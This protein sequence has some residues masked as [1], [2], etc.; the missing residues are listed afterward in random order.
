[1]KTLEGTTDWNWD[2]FQPGAN[3]GD[4]PVQNIGNVGDWSGCSLFPECPFG[5]RRDPTSSAP[6]VCTGEG[7]PIYQDLGDCLA[8]TGAT[9]TE[10]R[11]F[12]IRN[13]MEPFNTAF[14]ECLAA[15]NILG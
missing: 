4:P 6:I 9:S 1:M 8:A 14:K 5:Q 10:H 13:C 3:P 12:H 11:N 15:L 7:V 2:V